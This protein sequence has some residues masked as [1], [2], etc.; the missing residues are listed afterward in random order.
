MMLATSSFTSVPRKTIRSFKRRLKMSQLRSPR[1]VVS[2]TCGYGMK[3]RGGSINGPP[4]ACV[5]SRSSIACVRFSGRRDM[6]ALLSSFRDLGLGFD[7]V[8]DLVLDDHPD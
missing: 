2:T 6:D 3:L 1:C 5:F 8:E 7:D 4:A